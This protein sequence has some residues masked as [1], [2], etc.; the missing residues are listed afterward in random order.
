MKYSLRNFLVVFFM[1]IVIFAVAAVFLMQYISNSILSSP[2]SDEGGDPI[3]STEQKEELSENVKNTLSY[4]VVGLDDE[5]K[6]AYLLLTHINRETGTFLVSDLPA[7]LRIELDGTYRTLGETALDRGL[8]FVRDKVYAL[9]TVRPDY[10]FAV[11]ADGF[12]DLVDR[13]GGFDFNV[14]RAMQQTFPERGVRIDLAA[15]KQH[16]NG[17]LALQVLQ[18][19]GYDTDVT[20]SRSETFRALTVAMCRGILTADNNLMRASEMLPELFLDFTTDMTLGDANRHLDTLFSFGSYELAEFTYPGRSDGT[21]Y[22]PDTTGAE[23]IYKDY[24]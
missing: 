5:G 20:L 13:F 15:G 18:F 21:Y 6:A 7:N 9:T 19:S 10:L 11:E 8:E 24:R 12:R 22:L 4:L 23:E 14:P 1:S 2:I 16:L 17:A 3:I